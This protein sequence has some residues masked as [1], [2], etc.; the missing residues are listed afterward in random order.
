MVFVADLI[1]IRANLFWYKT[2]FDFHFLQTK[3]V[4]E[5]D[6]PI[7]RIKKISLL[8]IPALSRNVHWYCSQKC[9]SIVGSFPRRMYSTVRRAPWHA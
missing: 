3:I 6:P 7:Q 5:K 4:I 8:C 1:F 9:R 2:V